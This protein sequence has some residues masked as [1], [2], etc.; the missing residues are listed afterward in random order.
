MSENKNLNEMKWDGMLELRNRDLAVLRFLSD[1]DGSL[2][3]SGNLYAVDHN[4][5][6]K[7]IDNL[8]KLGV[9]E[10]CD[11][12]IHYKITD[13]GR[14]CLSTGE[15]PVT[16]YQYGCEGNTGRIKVRKNDICNS[17]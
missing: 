6:M 8:E 1:N 7:D 12:N 4:L 9:I 3:D 2:I 17:K 5:E 16:I 14:E 11:L 15:I 13:F 10:S